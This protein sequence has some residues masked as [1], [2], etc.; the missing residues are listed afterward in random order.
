MKVRISYT[1][2]LTDEIREGLANHYGKSLPTLRS[3]VPT[4][5]F[6]CRGNGEG[7]L[8]DLALELDMRDEHEKSRGAA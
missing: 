4:L 3:A 8:D 1:V 6:F 2:E 5:K 7:A